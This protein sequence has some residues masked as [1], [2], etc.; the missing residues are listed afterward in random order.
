MKIEDAKKL[1]ELNPDGSAPLTFYAANN[2]SIYK[3]IK[4]A[5]GLIYI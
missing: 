4:S 3:S 1:K 2:G 5:I